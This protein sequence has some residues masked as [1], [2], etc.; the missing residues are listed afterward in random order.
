MT[1]NENINNIPRP[2][3]IDSWT[4]QDIVYSCRN[5]GTEFNFYGDY[6][7]YCHHCGQKQEWGRIQLK[8]KQKITDFNLLHN[9]ELLDNIDKYNIERTNN[10]E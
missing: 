1:K 10:Y 2:K 5:C 4:F 3:R 8:L 7:K 9:Q 6:E